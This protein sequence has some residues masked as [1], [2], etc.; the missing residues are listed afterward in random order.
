MVT[1]TAVVKNLDEGDKLT[2]LLAGKLALGRNFDNDKDATNV[3]ASVRTV[4]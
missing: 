1:L 3:L 2:D 4:E